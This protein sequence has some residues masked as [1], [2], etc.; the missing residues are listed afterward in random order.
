M[1]DELIGK[2]NNRIDSIYISCKMD[3]YNDHKYRREYDMKIIGENLRRCREKNNLSVI[4][5]RD[6]LRI[7]SVQSIYKWEEGL[8]YPQADNLLALMEL[9]GAK[10]SDI[11]GTAEEKMRFLVD[12]YHY[13]E[14]ERY[15]R[16]KEYVIRMGQ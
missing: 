6:Y 8:C 7:G 14:E 16:I 4:Y 12:V 5:V 2:Y 13:D 15:K 11:I 3:D 10:L 9:Y 1:G